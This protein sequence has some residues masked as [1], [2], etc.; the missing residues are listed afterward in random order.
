M[1]LETI[2][3]LTAEHC[4]TDMP[5]ITAASEFKALGL[6]SLDITEIILD[7]EEEF[8]MSIDYSVDTKVKTVGEL[9]EMVE[10]L[11]M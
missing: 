7:L 10:Q 4:D 3:R 11:L 1:L 2:I 8:G 5:E 6:D 9:A